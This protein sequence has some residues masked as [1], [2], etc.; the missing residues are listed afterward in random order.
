MCSP[1]CN[2]KLLQARLEPRRQVDRM[3]GLVIAVTNTFRGWIFSGALFVAACTVVAV[4][5]AGS[6]GAAVP[7]TGNNCQL[8]GKISGRGATFATVA[9][10]TFADGFRDD[11]CGKVNDT[12]GGDDMVI[13]NF[14]ATTGS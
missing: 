2:P 4:V 9:W 8:S 13:Y 10:R 3:K 5:F 14:D 11:V 6:G 1:T 12:P 7:P